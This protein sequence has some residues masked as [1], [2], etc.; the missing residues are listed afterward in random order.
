MIGSSSS[1][2]GF[3]GAEPVKRRYEK[4]GVFLLVWLAISI[5][6]L[7]VTRAWS[8]EVVTRGPY[9]Q[10]GTENSMVVRWW[11]DQP[12]DSEV[13]FGPA[14]GNLTD[15]V[16]D[17]TST[18][19]HE[20][21]LTLLDADT[22]Y[23]YAV[24]TTLDI[25]AGDDAGHFFVTSPA[26]GTA[27]RTRVWVVGDS[28]TAHKQQ[29]DPALGE[30][31]DPQGVRDSFL[32]YSG[33]GV[34][35]VSAGVDWKYLDDGS[36]QGTAWRDP[37][38]DD[39]AWASG[40]SELG[41]G[42]GDE[43]TVVN[44]GPSA[45]LCN[46][47]NNLITT[48][49]RRSFNV[50]DASLIT[51]LTLTLLRDDGAVVYLNGTEVF[52]SNMP[53]GA[54]DFTTS[55]SLGVGS[56]AE[57]IFHKTGVDPALLV[58]GTNV[59]AVE[60]HQISPASSDISFNLELFGRTDGGTAADLWLTLGDNAYNTGTDD[61]WQQAVFNPYPALL[62][63]IPLWPSLGNHDIQTLDGGPYHDIMTLPTNAEAGGVASGT[64]QYYSFDYG[65][66]HFV[67][68]DSTHQASRQP[69][70][71]MLTWLAND[72]AATSQDW[73]IAYW[74]HAPYTKGSH[75]SDAEGDLIDMRENVLPVLEAGGVDL[76]LVGHSHNYERSILIDGFYA[77]PTTIFDG[78]LVDP[79]DGCVV[80]GCDGPYNKPTT[81]PAP[82]EGT[83]YAVVGNSGRNISG[84]ASL[85]HPVMS[86]S[87]DGLG[88]MI[89]DID[90]DRLDATLI[91]RDCATENDPGCV[92]DRFTIVKGTIQAVYLELGSTVDSL[93]PGEVFPFM[94]DLENITSQSQS[95]VLVL[96]LGLPTGQTLTLVAA[97]ISL[98]SLVAVPLELS[99]PLPA[100]APLGTWT[101][102]GV[103]VQTGPVLVDL[104]SKTFTVE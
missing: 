33:T 54:I 55:A 92:V 62:R 82:H 52:R 69:G 48:Y 91:N 42:D 63:N 47:N 40:P 10:M 103:A 14:P 18:V 96:L 51:D 98:P 75:D 45:P 35:L 65:N 104:S 23:F 87:A 66:I 72:L 12:T 13:S 38:F 84:L 34:G 21:T 46:A 81:G 71:A 58:N 67:A 77:T 32:A 102:T 99:L 78:T 83:V 2:D 100:A 68:V 29:L 60:A 90:G 57:H 88:S 80:T 94:L 76:V 11:T 56:T 97:P 79:G 16:D 74:H 8:Q 89:L 3:E 37:A 27:K 15:A 6:A 64:E 36:D 93:A 50:A 43:A 49:F 53:A 22:K 101:I 19:A 7:P 44:C 95:F 4:S 9:L 31:R 70:S 86:F 85:D 20:I 25:L 73:I 41:Y 28:G 5:V 17:L 26:A 39:T 59:L 1:G 30:V 24:G 61:E